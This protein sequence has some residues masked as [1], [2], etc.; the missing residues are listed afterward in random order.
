M[1]VFGYAVN[2]AHCE[3]SAQRH[4]IRRNTNAINELL[5]V[6]KDHNW[7]GAHNLY[8]SQKQIGDS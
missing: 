6:P 3:P 8:P 2:P 5:N 1:E 4:V 7:Q